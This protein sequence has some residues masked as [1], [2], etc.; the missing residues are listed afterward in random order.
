MKE[1]RGGVYS[2]FDHIEVLEM[3]HA[4][5][6]CISGTEGVPEYPVFEGY[7][8]YCTKNHS[9]FSRGDT[10]LQKL[11]LQSQSYMRQDNYTDTLKR[12]L[13]L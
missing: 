8:L 11:K 10:S 1:L 3:V 7:Y 9:T 5:N 2:V 4:T 6:T 12:A 13:V